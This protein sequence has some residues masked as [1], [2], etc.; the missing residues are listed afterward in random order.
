MHEAVEGKRDTTL[1]LEF[2]RLRPELASALAEF[3]RVLTKS[4]ATKQFHPHPFT[5]EEAVWICA[6]SGRDLYSAAVTG[7]EV[8]GYGLLR[9]WD[10]GFEVPSLGIAIHPFYTG[11]GLGRALMHYLHSFARLR[12]AKRIR[13]KV[14]PDNLRA[15]RLYETLGYRF[16]E[17]LSGEQLVGYLET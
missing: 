9:G 11:A 4:G 12:G 6:Y 8:L 15:V 2:L 3:F 17:K 10:E 1:S 5:M 14:Y 16:E 7:G 13:L